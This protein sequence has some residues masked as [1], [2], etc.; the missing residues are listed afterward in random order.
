[1]GLHNNRFRPVPKWLI[2][3]SGFKSSMDQNVFP[4]VLHLIVPSAAAA[5]AAAAADAAAAAAIF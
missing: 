1:M 3:L 4:T 2:L 5:A